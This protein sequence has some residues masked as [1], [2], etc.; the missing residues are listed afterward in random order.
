MNN[1]AR[2][3][4][5]SALLIVVL[6]LALAAVGDRTLRTRLPA[7]SLRPGDV[8]VGGVSG[9]APARFLV[10]MSAGEY[11]ELTV[12]QR[13]VDL[14]VTV[15]DGAWPVAEF[16]APSG[17]DG[18]EEVAFVAAH[19]G[20]F[21]VEVRPL[22]SGDSGGYRLELTALRP[23]AGLDRA[24]AAAAT[25]F[26]AAERLRSAGSGVA[27]RAAV[28]S[29][30]AAR[31]GFHE[32]GAPAREALVLRRLAEALCEL[33]ES[34]AAVA[35][36]REARDLALRSGLESETVAI[37]NRLGGTYAFLGQ[38][39]EAAAAHEEALARASAHADARGQAASLTALGRL[40]QSLGDFQSALVSFDQALA[41]WRTLEERGFEAATLQS[42]GECYT[43]IG[44]SDEALDLIQAAAD[45]C[46]HAGDRRGLASAVTLIG[47]I[48]YWQGDARAA[49]GEYDE[50]L[51][52]WDQIGDQRGQAGAWDR[53]GTALLA[54]GALDEA[55][56]AYAR[57]LAIC[58]RNGGRLDEA[59]V[60]ANQA[61]LE[62]A[63][64]DLAASVRA[65]REATAAFRSLRDKEAE[66][67]ALLGW[68]RVE[69][70]LGRLRAARARVAAALQIVESLRGGLDSPGLR[71]TYLAARHELYTTYVTL[72]MQEHD[73]DPGAGYDR[74][75]FEVS[76]RSR[77]RSLLELVVHARD[78]AAHP[79]QDAPDEGAERSALRAS[80]ERRIRALATGQDAAAGESELRALLLDYDRLERLPS[81]ARPALDVA[82][83]Q[84]LL[85]GDTLLIEY[86]LADEGSYVWFLGRDTFGSRRL[87]P[88]V[89][90]ERLALHVHRLLARSRG[91]SARTAWVNAARELS[92]RVLAPICHALAGKRLVI[93][94]DGALHDVP[95]AALPEPSCAEGRAAAGTEF[96]PLVTRHEIVG[97]PAGSLLPLLRRPRP[98]PH[99]RTLALFA[100]PVFEADDVRVRARAGS[101]PAR[102]P[103]APGAGAPASLRARGFV[104]GT[105]KRLASTRDEAAAILRL[106]RPG[107]AFTALDF[108]ANRD[109]VLAA[110]LREYRILH[111]ATHGLLNERRPELS[112]LV[113]SLVDPA[114]RPRDGF[115]S[116]HDVAQ[117][118]APADL[119]VLSACHTAA[120][121][122]VAGEGILGPTRS[123]FAAGAQRVIVS[124]WDVSDVATSQLMADMY[125]QLLR[126]G[127]PPA[128]ALRAAQ[129]RLLED[130]RWRAPFY[131]AGFTLQGDWR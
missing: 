92:Q 107:A 79:A 121:R 124:L 44:Y 61:K 42:L 112:G 20:A 93:V 110:D 31:A 21:I 7:A 26:G 14:V 35:P 89:E 87:A 75:A 36:L 73:R 52:L 119:V 103:A 120:G 86:L 104:L 83:L 53:R 32:L 105:F 12:Q 27:L 25:A 118:D 28:A 58:R 48:R 122:G 19:R 22:A 129:L 115:L 56:A 54:L 4:E 3:R 65:Y 109:T 85:D 17:A 29:Y 97:L 70:R 72:L 113:L 30:H 102:P 81:Q 131:W 114:G 1:P 55:R 8:I 39:R 128:Q 23:A 6:A 2:A 68:A 60:R 5:P 126:H 90:I 63:Q 51:K 84:G 13:R 57:A 16:D 69:Q 82:A 96:T 41:L 49:L 24:R 94:A 76:E 101:A 117:L 106:V 88:R 116:A 40:H 11:L 80:V 95:F 59:H 64:G 98:R 34:G 62:A 77:A 78:R 50:A 45:L 74:E 46:R 99:R 100:D 15:L 67:H 111:F 47:W 127:R 130:E 66:A 123:F 91:A 71:A 9:P 18:P 33:G 37:L 10:P 38:A 108:D 43:R 125:A